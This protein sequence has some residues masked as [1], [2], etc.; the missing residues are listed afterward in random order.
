MSRNRKSRRKGGK[1]EGGSPPAKR[2]KNVKVPE[3][4]LI[5]EIEIN[6]TEYGYA[7][8]VDGLGGIVVVEHAKPKDWH[9]VTLEFG[10]DEDPPHHILM[11][12]ATAQE[13]YEQLDDIFGGEDE[14]DEEGEGDTSTE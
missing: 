7:A 1:K 8:T 3:P 13:L 10:G 9:E 11:D 6:L 4:I 14:D 2:A 5:G 12:L